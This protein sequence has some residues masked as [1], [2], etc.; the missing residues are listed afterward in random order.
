[1]DHIEW[2]QGNVGSGTTLADELE[3]SYTKLREVHDELAIY[4]GHVNDLTQFINTLLVQRN[5]I[6]AAHVVYTFIDE[7][8]SRYPDRDILTLIKQWLILL[9]GLLNPPIK[10]SEDETGSAEIPGM[11][12]D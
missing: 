8:R 4:Q 3:Q 1:M 7:F 10:P 6:N 5:E 9:E 12:P 2:A 11:E